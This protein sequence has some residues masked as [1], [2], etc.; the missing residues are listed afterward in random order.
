MLFRNRFHAPISRGEVTRTVR[1]WSRPQARVGGRYAVG[2]TLIEVT[3]IGQRQL[4]ELTEEDAKHCGVTSTAALVAEMGRTSRGQ[5]PEHVW[6]ID[7]RAV[8]PVPA[9]E[10]VGVSAE[11]VGIARKK[12]EAMDARAPTPWTGMFL[13]LI[14]ARPAVAARYLAEDVGMERL[15]FKADVRR[16][17]ALGLTN[18]L[19][20]GYEL[21][22][23]GRAVMEAM[24]RAA[25]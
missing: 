21:T 18:S 1:A 6:V 11:A 16:L 23:L 20:V 15:A 2:G 19:E 3:A 7:F 10:P 4:A 25:R 22:E 14:G 13:A 17:K 9:R 12:L 5:T 24:E 8:G